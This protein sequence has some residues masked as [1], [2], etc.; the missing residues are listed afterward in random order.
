MRRFR[1]KIEESTVSGERR[2]YVREHLGWLVGYAWTPSFSAS[3]R[4]ACERWIQSINDPQTHKA[5][6]AEEARQR[7]LMIHPLSEPEA[8]SVDEWM[9]RRDEESPASSLLH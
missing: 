8:L 1:L 7:L 5:R 3:T 4:E 9:R 2:F 6:V